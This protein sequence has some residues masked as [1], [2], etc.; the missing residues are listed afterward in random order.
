MKNESVGNLASCLLNVDEFLLNVSGAKV[1]TRRVSVQRRQYNV[2]GTRPT[3]VGSIVPFIAA[4]GTLLY[5]AL[6]L[7]PSANRVKGTTVDGKTVFRT[8]ITP[9]KAD[10]QKWGKRGKCRPNVVIYRNTGCVDG[11]TWHEIAKCFVAHVQLHHPGKEFT[12]LLD[13]LAAHTELEA[14]RMLKGGA[15]R[16]VYLPKNTSHFSQPLDDKVFGS[17]RRT[18]TKL[19]NACGMSKNWFAEANW[20][21]IVLEAYEEAAPSS[22]TPTLICA[23]FRDCGQYP[24]SPDTLR[25]R[26]REAAGVSS[27]PTESE[28]QATVAE[29]ITMHVLAKHQQK[30][31]PDA[32]ATFATQV[33]SHQAYLAEDVFR[34]KEEQKRAADLKAADKEQRQQQRANMLL[35]KGAP[36]DSWCCQHGAC[37]QKWSRRTEITWHECETCELYLVCDEHADAVTFMARHEASCSGEFNPRASAPQ[38]QKRRRKQAATAAND[39]ESHHSDDENGVND[40]EDDEAM[41][42]DENAAREDE[43]RVTN[44]RLFANIASGSVAQL[45]PRKKRTPNRKYI[46]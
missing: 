33:V 24:W 17:L 11:E 6:I 5:S 18:M 38:P 16:C 22:F 8:L 32:D 34:I 41:N 27:Q 35:R 44:E 19:V 2:R 40:D 12:L 10:A 29:A 28:M 1:T 42:G 21:S 36:A 45:L 13:N 39:N 7:Q 3:T 14:L 31:R 20:A 26:A 9:T 43:V 46:I 30:R 25:R 23:S 37:T 15:V 4:D